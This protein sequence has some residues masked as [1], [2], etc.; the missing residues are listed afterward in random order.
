MAGGLSLIHIYLSI[1]LWVV[2]QVN[3]QELACYFRRCLKPPVGTEVNFQSFHATG[4]VV[5]PSPILPVPI[6]FSPLHLGLNRGG[7]NMENPTPSSPTAGSRFKY[8]SDKGHQ[9]DKAAR[10]TASLRLHK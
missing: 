9:C 6:S 7:G 8:N 5:C 4:E 10:N 3:A 2:L 1:I